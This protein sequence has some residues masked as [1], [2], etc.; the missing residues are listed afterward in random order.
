[1]VRAGHTA[2]RACNLVYE[3]YGHSTGVTETTRKLDFG[4]IVLRF[5]VSEF[6]NPMVFKF[7]I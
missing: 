2:D 6:G 3:A 1:M 4:R 7:E 5:G